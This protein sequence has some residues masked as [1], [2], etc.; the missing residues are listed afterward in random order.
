MKKV[1]QRSD[2]TDEEYSEGSQL[3]GEYK[4]KQPIADCIREYEMLAT[5]AEERAALLRTP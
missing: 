5:A 2:Y 3:W 1:F 4:G